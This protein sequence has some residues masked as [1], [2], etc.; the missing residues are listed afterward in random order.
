MKTS[1]VNSA[2]SLAIKVAEQFGKAVD[3]WTRK[4]RRWKAVAF[5]EVCQRRGIPGVIAEAVRHWLR[6]GKLIPNFA[7]PMLRLAAE[8][9]VAAKNPIEALEVCMKHHIDS[10][11][12]SFVSS[13]IKKLMPKS[14]VRMGWQAEI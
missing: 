6:E 4:G 14:P 12:Y 11:V 10:T 13:E 9:A 7:R 1:L 2:L 5:R 3:I 8:I